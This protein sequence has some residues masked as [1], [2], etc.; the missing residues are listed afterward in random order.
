MYRIPSCFYFC[1]VAFFLLAG[2]SVFVPP[3]KA[4]INS[5]T[6]LSSN[7]TEKSSY[8]LSGTVVNS[9]TGEPVSR[10]LVQISSNQ[11]PVFHPP[12]GE[13]D[14][15]NAFDPG[16][17]QRTMLTD[18]EGRFKFEGLPQM[19]TT[20]IARKPGFFNQQELNEGWPRENHVD[21]GPDAPAV[22]IK[23]I[24]EAVITGH[25]VD[26]NGEPL[27]GVI[28]RISGLLRANGRKQLQALQQEQEQ[29]QTLGTDEDGEFRIANLA[30]GTYYLAAV[31][32]P[33]RDQPQFASNPNVAYPVTYYPGVAEFSEA[34]PIRLAPGQHAQMDFTL[35]Q[36][37]VV[38]VAG[39]ITGY[40]HGQEADVQFLNQSGDD[41]ALE[42]QFDPQ[43]GKFEARIVAAGLC[44]IK[45][46]AKDTFERLLHAELTVSATTNAKNLRLS[47]TPAL[48]IPIV[49]RVETT[50]FQ[51]EPQIEGVG[52]IGGSVV[53]VGSVPASVNLHPIDIGHPDL[54]A[55]V[56][57][58]P[59]NPL[60]VLRNVEAG[61]YKVE[62]VPNNSNDLS[63][64]VKSIQYGGADLL[65]E[66][67]TVTPGQSSTME[68]VLRDDS[69]TLSGTVQSQENDG[70]AAVL[71]VPD[72]APLDPKMTV[73]D[74]HGDFQI[75]GLAPGEYKVFAFDRLDGLEYSNPDVLSE[76]ASK[77]AQVSLQPN[78]KTTVRVG[79][80]P[81]GE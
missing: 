33:I 74:D 44:T 31:P 70:Q 25:V 64:Y 28:I 51:S 23:L 15:P 65:R 17:R 61:K 76:Y 69:A 43:T 67:L 54:T 12:M 37:P 29:P 49:V 13:E 18:R 24:P 11:A 30:P 75:D 71:V 72:Y 14:D 38:S 68:I 5:G 2:T 66:E 21:V 39:V 59:R 62:V 52:T 45:A 42:K 46:D 6:F 81:R 36:T 55:N 27:E 3:A 7:E 63:L 34:E 53:R 48:S 57:G 32:Y 41:V 20:L 35:R 4:Q 10:A 50:K 58:G 79:L 60:L 1:S 8:T 47:L 77:A 26:A 40:P 73:A 22:V 78:E 16:Y 19:R 56:E 9:V 80:I